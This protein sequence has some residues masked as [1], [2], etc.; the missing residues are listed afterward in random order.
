MD[1]FKKLRKY[2]MK[3]RSKV[4]LSVIVANYNNEQF[5]RDAVDSVLDQTCKD[6]E[7]VVADD[8]SSDN[9]PEIIRDYEKKHPGIVR[10][11]FS[12]AN[13]G[14]AWARHE[15]ILEA[16]GEYITTLDSDDYYYDSRKLE[17]E[18]K[19][20]QFYKVKEHKDILAFSNI[21]LVR[22]D[23][24]VIAQQGNSET[25]REGM[26]FEDIITRSCMIPRDFIMNKVAYF[27]AGGY[28]LSI[29]MYEDWDLKLRLAAIYNF[30]YTG[31]DG[32]AY[33]QHGSGLSS[34][35]IP[36]H[37][38][39]LNTIFNKNIPLADESKKGNI[40]QLYGQFIK[41]LKANM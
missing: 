29:P 33:R 36:E 28:D 15:A 39:W 23:K 6:L 30:Y 13:S 18:I 20:I 21:V 37:I 5:V 35:P 16:R 25:V 7:I 10:G 14:V 4:I 34:V 38:K 1:G 26:I 2:V 41:R 31:I 22:R 27:E 40:T 11:L 19:L 32:T 9:S 8:G 12:S 17:K 24:E 3:E